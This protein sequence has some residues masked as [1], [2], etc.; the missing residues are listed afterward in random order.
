[1]GF[2]FSAGGSISS[3]SGEPGPDTGRRLRFHGRG[4]GLRLGC[5]RW[6]L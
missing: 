3:G 1:M 4:S 5:E 2:D 6:Q